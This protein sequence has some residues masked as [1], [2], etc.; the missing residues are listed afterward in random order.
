M[1]TRRETRLVRH[2]RIRKHLSG[3]AERP[4]LS[5]YRS[6][7]HVSAQVIDDSRGVTLAAASSVEKAVAK[8]GNKEGAKAV[9]LL[10]AKRALEKGIRNVVFDRGG[11]KY[12]GRVAA[13]AEGAREGGLEF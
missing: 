8:S 4:R 12:A 13:L 3:S 2:K 5:V 10:V 9:G 11:Y 6:L 1:K 7:R